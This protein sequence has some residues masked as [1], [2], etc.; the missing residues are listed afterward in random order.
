MRLP[1]KLQVFANFWPPKMLNPLS[2]LYSPDLSTPGYF[3]SPKLKM[4]LKRLHFADVTE[5]QEAVT[6]ELKNVPPPPPQ[7][8]R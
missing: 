6:D 1:T 2:P 3:L 4:R 5:I 8:K 7:K